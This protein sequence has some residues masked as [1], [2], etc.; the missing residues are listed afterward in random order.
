ML[1]YNNPLFYKFITIKITKIIFLYL[2]KMDKLVILLIVLFTFLIVIFTCK[3]DFKFPGGGW[4]TGGRGM[5]NTGGWGPLPVGFWTPWSQPLIETSVKPKEAAWCWRRVSPEF[6][7]LS[8][9]PSRDEWKHWA[10][11]QGMSTILFNK[12][13]N[14][15]SFVLIQ[16]S[17][18]PIFDPTG[19]G[20]DQTNCFIKADADI[21]SFQYVSL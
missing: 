9:T 16:S 18:Q 21:S 7:D 1:T 4:N 17:S 6:A 5:W 3:E 10:R 14:D 20:S 13:P 8:A 19:A 12:D 15:N 2:R 11:R